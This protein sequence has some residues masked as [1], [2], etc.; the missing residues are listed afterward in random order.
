LKKNSQ[1]NARFIGLRNESIGP[2]GVNV[3]R[4]FGQDVKSA[5]SSRDACAACIA[6]GLP[7]ATYP[8]DG[9]RETGLKS[10]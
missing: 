4:F 1:P 7:I 6:E 2:L 10:K 3:D 9:V 8:W 5:P